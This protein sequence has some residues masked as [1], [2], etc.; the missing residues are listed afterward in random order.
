MF[1]SYKKKLSKQDSSVHLGRKIFFFLISSELRHLKGAPEKTVSF[2]GKSSG[3]YKCVLEC[4]AVRGGGG[5]G[6][7]RGGERRVREWEE[8]GEER[9]R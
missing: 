2:V 9:G 7:E 3:L 5:G 4:M 6:R 1:Y 8:G